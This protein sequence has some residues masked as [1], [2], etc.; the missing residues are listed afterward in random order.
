MSVQDT[1]TYGIAHETSLP[2]FTMHSWRAVF[3][4]KGTEQLH[5][6]KTAAAR[7]TLPS[8]NSLRQH[9][10]SHFQT[11]RRKSRAGSGDCSQ[12]GK[13]GDSSGDNCT[14]D[15]GDGDDDAATGD[16][17]SGGGG[18]GG[19]DASGDADGGDGG[20][21]DGGGG[22]PVAAVAA[23]AAAPTGG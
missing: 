22:D 23:T 4:T 1:E 3:P 19:G 10:L 15:N 7:K 18:D 5:M 12:S 2:T 11:R 17:D 14:D 9:L 6:N 20:G 13:C 21:G 16:G 8:A